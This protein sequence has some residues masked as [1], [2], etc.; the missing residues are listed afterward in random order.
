M[1]D[2]Y[3]ID[4][5]PPGTGILARFIDRTDG[6]LPTYLTAWQDALTYALAHPLEAVAL[7][8]EMDA[9]AGDFTEADRLDSV[10]EN[11]RRRLFAELTLVLGQAVR[12]G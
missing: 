8:H 9:A 12:H 6:D 4:A 1:P 3:G 11:A 10:N 5:L 7:L 2:G